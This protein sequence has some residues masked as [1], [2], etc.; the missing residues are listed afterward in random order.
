M[1]AATD[2]N[3]RPAVATGLLVL[4]VAAALPLLATPIDTPL[5]RS[6][7]RHILLMSAAAP[8][9]ALW[10]AR[11]CSGIGTSSRLARAL[12]P[13]V[14]IQAAVLYAWH[15]PAGHAAA[16]SSPAGAILMQ[17]SL[18]AAAIWFWY[19]VVTSIA[20]RRWHAVLGLALTGKVFCLLGVLLV[21]ARRPLFGAGESTASAL[22]DQQLAGLLMLTACPATYIAVAFVISCR[23]LNLLGPDARRDAHG[24][25]AA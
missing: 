7:A 15:L 9:I 13:A 19:A 17:L 12:F 23:G 11:L 5:A 25:D 6:M 14:G 21:F 20:T 3:G 4:G 18:L 22:A 16:M 1:P 8:L 24:S 10:L 2:V